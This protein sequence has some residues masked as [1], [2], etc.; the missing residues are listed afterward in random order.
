LTIFANFSASS[1]A[2]FKLHVFYIKYECVVTN[3]GGLNGQKYISN[4]LNFQELTADIRLRSKMVKMLWK[5]LAEEV[6][7][8]TGQYILSPEFS[9][10]WVN[11]QQ[12][13]QRNRF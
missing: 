9:T 10:D 12:C 5:Q 1:L 3:K 13:I 8:L 4:S 7:P 6:K 2:I 11:L